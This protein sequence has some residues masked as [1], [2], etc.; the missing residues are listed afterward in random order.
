M[1]SDEPYPEGPYAAMRQRRSLIGMRRVPHQRVYH[2]E[3]TLD[4]TAAAW[5]R[6][7]MKILWCGSLRET[8]ARFGSLAGAIWP[9]RSDL[10]GESWAT[11]RMPRKLSKRRCYACGSTHHAGVQRQLSALGSIEWWL[12]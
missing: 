10:R 7:V 12:I 11:R 4:W 1:P 2:G 6:Q 5:T 8:R 9:A 3:G